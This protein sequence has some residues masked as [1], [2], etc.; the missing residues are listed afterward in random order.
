M[1]RIPPIDGNH[2]VSAVATPS[3]TNDTSP[4]TCSRTKRMIAITPTAR[5]PGISRTVCNNPMSEPSNAATSIT[6]LFNSADH[7]LN[8]IGMANAMR[9]SSAT[10]R[11]QN[12]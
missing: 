6:K 1:V 7:V 11:R 2:A 12:G 9:N 3:S 10:G 4:R 8:A 5:K